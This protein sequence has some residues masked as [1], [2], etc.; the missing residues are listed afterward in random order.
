M[1]FLL[2]CVVLAAF[3][4]PNFTSHLPHWLTD[5]TDMRCEL[6]SFT[7]VP[8][9]ERS[10]VRLTLDKL[11]CASSS[12][13]LPY[14]VGSTTNINRRRH[15]MDGW[16]WFCILFRFMPFLS[17]LLHYSVLAGVIFTLLMVTQY[18]AFHIPFN[19]FIHPVLSDLIRQICFIRNSFMF[20]PILSC[21]FNFAVDSL[22]R[23]VRN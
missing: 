11:F 7:S 21:R 13:L 19:S 3:R 2:S 16:Y 18:F 12:L 1:T 6:Q 17:V 15:I 20:I 22:R 9:I 23:T 14:Q 4:F 8:D 5:W 10:A